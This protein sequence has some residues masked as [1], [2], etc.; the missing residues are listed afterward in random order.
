[1]RNEPVS[2]I[3]LA[4]SA[5]E[6]KALIKLTEDQL[7]RARFIDP[8]IPGYTTNLQQLRAAESGLDR[9]R[10]ATDTQHVV[11]RKLGRSDIHIRTKFKI[12]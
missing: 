4:L 1:M 9:L 2:K 6:L 10:A 7:F 12:V 11:I 8:K 3:H 5:D